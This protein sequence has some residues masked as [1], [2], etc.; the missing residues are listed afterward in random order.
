MVLVVGVADLADRRHAAHVDAPVLAGRHAQRRIAPSRA[1][2]CAPMPRGAHELRAL[3]G[4]GLDR[5][6]HRAERDLPSASALPVRIS[7]SSPD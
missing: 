7:A 1:I 2:S 4:L 5:V 3:A 6:Q